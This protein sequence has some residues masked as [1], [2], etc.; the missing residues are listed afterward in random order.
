MSR[1][2]INENLNKKQTLYVLTE[3]RKKLTIFQNKPSKYARTACKIFYLTSLKNFKCNLSFKTI[4]NVVK[5][6]VAFRVNYEFYKYQTVF[7][8]KLTKKK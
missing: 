8:G 5:M 7:A 2:V 3:K 1:R 6:P 4:L